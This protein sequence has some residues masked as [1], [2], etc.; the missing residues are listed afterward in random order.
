MEWYNYHR[1][2][3][4]DNGHAPESGRCARL[5]VSELP[6]HV[7]RYLHDGDHVAFRIAERVQPVAGLVTQG[8][9]VIYLNGCNGKKHGR[10]RR[11]LA[12]RLDE[13]EDLGWQVTIEVDTFGTLTFGD[14]LRGDDDA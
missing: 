7:S 11:Q 1:A 9:R 3:L 13:A 2:A 10:G 5:P 12:I 8:G 4:T 6:P 14:S